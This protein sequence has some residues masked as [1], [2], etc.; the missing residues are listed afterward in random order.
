MSMETKNKGRPKKDIHRD[1]RRT[2][3]F[4]CEEDE[5]IDYLSAIS[6]KS[7][8]DAIRSAV[9]RDYYMRKNGYLLSDEK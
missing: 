7:P 1:K 3:R 8:S 4:T 2:I 9:K 6:G 5:M